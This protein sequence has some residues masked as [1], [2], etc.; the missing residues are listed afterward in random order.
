MRLI[1]GVFT[2]ILFCIGQGVYANTTSET[3]DFKKSL[4]MAYENHPAMLEARKALQFAKG[5]LITARSPLNPE[6]ELEFG[7]LRK[8]EEGN[9][10]MN[11]DTIEIRQPF[12]PLGVGF[13]KS[14][15][16]SNEVKVHEQQ[17]K[18]TWA[19]VYTQVWQQY[20]EVI[21]SHKKLELAE[22]NLEA[23]RQ[24]FGKVQVKFQGGRILKN[25]LQRAKIELLKAENDFLQ[26]QN[27]LKNSKAQLNLSLGRSIDIDFDTEEELTEEELS[28]DFEQ[29]KSQA[30]ANRPD[31]K[32]AALELDSSRKNL[33]KEQVSRLPSYFIGFQKSDKADEK[34]YAVLFGFNV[35]IWNLNQGEVK[36]AKAEKEFQEVRQKSVTNQALLDV[37]TAFS[38]VELK[39][40][41]LELFKTSLEE[42]HELLRLA[43]TRYGEGKID[44]LNYLDQV[45]A[46]IE[47]K[48][49]YYEALLNY[50]Q[51]ISHLE[52]SING[53]LR[54][55]EGFHEKP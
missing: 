47:A 11:L 31:I 30:L 4:S 18:S 49:S 38:D 42:S 6:V 10:K 41:Q 16:A 14:K 28:L 17:L 1:I 46:S 5:D 32:I 23:M 9:R 35:P 39:K 21:I 26:A 3:L 40:Q 13:L 24:F 2:T 15:I 43:N 50:S 8:N 27:Q 44:F 37:Y 19:S 22:Q 12:N 52:T 7:G 20:S 25:E 45:T 36:K 29:I 51:S 48:T 33:V 55:E 53:S 34:D 54:G